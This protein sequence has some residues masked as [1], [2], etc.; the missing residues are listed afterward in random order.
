[1]DIHILTYLI[2]GLLMIALPIGLTIYLTHKFRLGWRLFWIG[3]G[4]LIFSQI[5][6][7]P[8]NALANPLFVSDKYF[9]LPMIWQN[10]FLAIFL[11]LS[12]GIFEELSRYMMY[13]WW[14]KDARSWSAGL[15]AGA[16]HGGIEAIILGLLVLYGYV[17][18]MLLR[19]MDIATIATPEKVE[20]VKNQI[21]AYWSAPWYFTLLGAI[22]RLFTIPL[23]LA[24]SILVLQTF[25]RK[26]SWWLIIAILFHAFMD[27]VA[28]YMLRIGSSA[29]TIEG[30][31]G[32]FAVI[33][34]GIVLLL[35]G[36]EPDV[37]IEI[38]NTIQSKL[39]IESVNET[40][41]NLDRTQYQ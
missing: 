3:A 9:T 35:K 10:I 31:I 8:F 38:S 40:H 26:N 2:N 39:I 29:F 4:T 33:S 25:R 23:H 34:I 30:I 22:E 32:I 17:Q 37:M 1:M 11:G 18:M 21:Q 6:H 27:G 41:D 16:G 19:G 15:L 12:A 7:I 36:R 20:L 5:L 24:C 14:A 13:R 28:V